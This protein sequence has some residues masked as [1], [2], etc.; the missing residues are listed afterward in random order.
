MPAFSSSSESANAY[1]EDAFAV[2]RQLRG[3]RGGN[4]FGETVG[5]DL[6]KRVGG[7]G[8]D[9]RHDQMRALLLDQRA[10]GGAVGHVDHVAAMRDLMTR[11]IRIT[12]DRDHFHAEALQRDDH[13]LAQFAR[14]QQHYARRR[15]RKRGADPL[16]DLHGV[17]RKMSDEMEWVDQQ[18]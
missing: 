2:H 3:A 6:G 15:V 12:V 8:F 7:D 16:A 4:H 17:S 1:G 9:L 13:F 11:R 10:Q 5:F 18:C 14:A